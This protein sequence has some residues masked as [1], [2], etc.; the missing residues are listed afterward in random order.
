MSLGERRPRADAA[1]PGRA[2]RSAS[3]ATP[4][5]TPLLGKFCDTLGRAR[6]PTRASAATR[7]RSST[8]GDD[9]HRPPSARSTAA[10]PRSAP[11]RTPSTPRSPAPAATSARR[12][13]AR[14]GSTTRS[15]TPCA[16]AAS[17]TTCSTAATSVLDKL[18]ELGQVSVTDQGN[19][20]DRRHVRRRRPAARRRHRRGQP[21]RSRSTAPG[22]KLGALQ[23]S[24]ADRSPATARSLDAVATQLA[25]RA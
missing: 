23:A 15:A 11:A 14:R 5:S 17:P 1:R 2:T 9:A 6:Q 4:D 16:A 25:D 22:G 19:G 21:G 18:C 20:I 10:W 24:Q 3:P 7:R 8:H 12:Q 13:R